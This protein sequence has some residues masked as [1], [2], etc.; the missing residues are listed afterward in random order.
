M[1]EINDAPV[2][3]V[4]QA[5]YLVAVTDDAESPAFQRVAA[6]ELGQIALKAESAVQPEQLG[7]AAFADTNS[8]L[9]PAVLD[10][11]RAEVQAQIDAL[12]ELVQTGAV[13]GD[14]VLPATFPFILSE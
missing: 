8:F 5:G 1:A 14:D 11:F 3:P 7:S 4:H 13:G 6:S 9:T 12:A 2:T 10:A